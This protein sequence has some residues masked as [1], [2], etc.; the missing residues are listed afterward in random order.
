MAEVTLVAPKSGDV[1]MTPAEKEERYALLTERIRTFLE[2][3][4]DLLAAMASIVCILHQGFPYY[5][6]TGFYRRTAVDALT[7][8]PYQGTL[9][10]VSIAFGRGVCGACATERRTLVVE[11]V[12]AFPGHIACDANS[13]SEIVVPVL[14]AAGD[15]IAVLDVDSAIPGA[16]DEVDARHLEGIVAL[17]G[18]MERVPVVCTA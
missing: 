18:R 6:W 12:H 7:V 16:F 3:E 4:H 10:C 5:F 15:L 9:G 2:P 8:G 13:A 17:L 11:D 1:R 14:D